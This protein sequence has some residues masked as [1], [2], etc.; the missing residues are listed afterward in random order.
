VTSIPALKNIQDE[1]LTE[2]EEQSQPSIF[3]NK[4]LQ[5]FGVGAGN[6]LEPK[7]S[8]PMMRTMRSTTLLAAYVPTEVHEPQSD[9]VSG[10]EGISPGLAG[11]N[12]PAV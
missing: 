6:E 1:K 4:I 8:P 11:V 9:D 10:P 2:S 12:T 5:P 3:N 7:T